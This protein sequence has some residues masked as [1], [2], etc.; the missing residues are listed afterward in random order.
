MQMRIANQQKLLSK[1]DFVNWTATSKF[2]D[3][4]LEASREEFCAFVAEGF[5]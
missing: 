2:V 1:Y 5:W 3:R 4:L